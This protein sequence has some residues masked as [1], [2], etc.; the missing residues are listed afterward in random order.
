MHQFRNIF[1]FWKCPVHSQGHL[2][3][4][5]QISFC[6]EFNFPY[7]LLLENKFIRVNEY[8]YWHFPFCSFIV[9]SFKAWYTDL[10]DWNTKLHSLRSGE[11]QWEFTDRERWVMDR[12][13]FFRSSIRH[14]KAP[15]KSVCTFLLFLRFIKHTG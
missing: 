15:V 7:N 10:R 14:R 6:I 4:K 3:L 2:V 11:G 1:M 5:H 12:F 8:I 9:D 13:M